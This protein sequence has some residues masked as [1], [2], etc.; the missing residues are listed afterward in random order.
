MA[1]I[2]GSSED[3]FSSVSSDISTEDDEDPVDHPMSASW[4]GESRDDVDFLLDDYEIIP[5][6]AITQFQEDSGE[7]AENLGYTDLSVSPQT[8][9]EL[10]ADRFDY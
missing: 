8:N 9:I 10:R 5:L 7:Y 3:T 6:S 1:T 4:H 2:P